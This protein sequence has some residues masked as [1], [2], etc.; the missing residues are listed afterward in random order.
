[1]ASSNPDTELIYAQND[2]PPVPHLL[3]L[4]LQQGMLLI[5]G[6]MLPVLLVKEI[7]GSTDMAITMV[8]LTMIVSGIGTIIQALRTRWLGSGYL[9]PN[10]GGPSYL[11]LSL[12]AVIQGGLPLMQGMLVFAG[13]VEMFLSRI[14]SRL[15]ALFPP[16]VVGMTVM[17]VGVSIIP[18]AFANFCGS[19][20]AGD[21]V[22]WQDIVVGTVTLVVIVGCNL[23][24]TGQVKLYCLLIGIFVGWGVSLS[25]T[26]FDPV[27]YQ[28]IEKAPLFAIPF[29]GLSQFRLAFDWSLV[30]P[31]LVIS[32]CGSL[33]SFGNLLAAQKITRPDLEK[34]D[35]DPIAG[36]LMADGL[37]TALAGLIGA[38]AVDTSSSNVGLAAAT[39]AVSRWIGVCMGVM[40]ILAG[41][42]PV[43]A[44]AI[45]LVPAPVMGAA[46]I[47]AICFMILTGIKEMLSEP[48]DQRNIAIAGMS[49]TFGLSTGFVPELFAQLPSFLQPLFSNP[50]AATTILGIIFYQIFHAD[51][52]LAALL[53]KK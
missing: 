26:P 17:M 31:F 29:T 33:K 19:P 35:M 5:L 27:R 24:G 11:A 12:T 21:V 18:M 16:L 28:M 6:T 7:G 42:F 53:K 43:V 9:C 22:I 37:S 44:T 38:V 15:R 41:C 39:R 51:T 49:I 2:V 45:A 34:P 30:L 14:V 8:S 10:I 48:M 25:I 23:W 1:M 47:F 20:V 50:L 36:G 40:Y 46:V 4:S 13:I 3:L 32:I 52:N